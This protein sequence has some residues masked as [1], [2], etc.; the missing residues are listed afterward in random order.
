MGHRPAQQAQLLFHRAQGQ[1]VGQARPC[2]PR[3]DRV[4]MI[5]ASPPRHSASSVIGRSSARCAAVQRDRAPRSEIGQ[6]CVRLRE[7]GARENAISRCQADPAHRRR[8]KQRPPRGRSIDQRLAVKDEQRVRSV[9]RP[10]HRT[11]SLRRSGRSA[12]ETRPLPCAASSAVRS[13]DS[14]QHPVEAHTISLPG[15]ALTTRL[16]HLMNLLTKS[17]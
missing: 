1:R 14:A 6:P 5:R 8:R 11:E 9:R 2:P 10:E 15:A 12:P 7:N 3:P 4:S 16:N 13:T 17:E